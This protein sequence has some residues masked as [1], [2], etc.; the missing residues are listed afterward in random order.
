MMENRMHA[1]YTSIKKA[2]VIGTLGV[3]TSG[4]DP[5]F[6]QL[7]NTAPEASISATDDVGVDLRSGK[8]TVDMGNLSIGHQEAPALS[9]N[10]LA[11]SGLAD[12]IVTDGVAFEN[13]ITYDAGGGYGSV[14]GCIYQGYS[15]RLNGQSDAYMVSPPSYTAPAGFTEKGKMVASGGNILTMKDGAIWEFGNGGLNI[16]SGNGWGLKGFL[17]KIT[18]PDGEVLTYYYSSGELR[19]IVSSTGYM[20]HLEGNKSPYYSSGGITIMD[21]GRPTKVVLINLAFQYCDPMAVSCSGQTIV[22]PSMSYSWQ[23]S[24]VAATDNMGRTRQHLVTGTGQF[25]QFKMI[26]PSGAWLEFGLENWQDYYISGGLT[27]A[28][29][30]RSA[31]KWVKTAVG[32]W[33]YEFTKNHACRGGPSVGSNV[34]TSPD[35][36]TRSWDKDALGRKTAYEI[37]TYSNQFGW[38]EKEVTR[39]TRPEGDRYDFLRDLRLNVKTLTVTSKDG[40]QTIAAEANFPEQCTAATAKYCNRPAYT[41]DANGNRTDYTYSPEHGGVLTKTLPA[42]ADGIRP[43]IRYTYQQMSAQFRNS[44]GQTVSGS[45]IWKAVSEA[46]CRTQASCTGTADELVTSYSYDGNLLPTVTTKTQGTGAVLEVVARVYD[47]VGNVISVDGPATGTAD[48]TYLFYDGARQL[49]GEIGP[50]PDGSGALPR[51]AKRRT[52]NADGKFASE[53]VGTVTGITQSLLDVMSVTQFTRNTYDPAT[54][55][56]V[57]TER[58]NP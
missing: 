32:Q 48:T 11:A 4:A 38:D 52:Y 15:Y 47:A 24:G 3:A 46:T 14:P 45:P 9:Y 30:R 36:T 42:G 54:G 13:C 53:E 2:I 56:L 49:T 12:A 22:W 6:A 7:L 57:K 19:S 29:D 41:I 43:Q 8:L 55:Q 18:R 23:P 17:T 5:A 40:T 39:I 20:L 44:A 28:C 37:S 21:P 34:S 10:V 58:G 51:P 1:G 35:G 16:Y 26:W 31:T 27:I 50:D 25:S 33:N